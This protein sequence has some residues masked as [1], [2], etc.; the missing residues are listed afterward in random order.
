MIS[1]TSSSNLR[2]E[3]DQNAHFMPTSE[4]FIVGPQLT[5]FLLVQNLTIARAFPD[6]NETPRSSTC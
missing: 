1:P 6:E 4:P 5:G 3:S 2:A